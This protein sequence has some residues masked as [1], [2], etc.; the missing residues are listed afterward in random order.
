MKFKAH[1][2]YS[3]CS[4]LYLRFHIGLINV[5]MEA[6]R[7]KETYI[8][9]PRWKLKRELLTQIKVHSLWQFK[10]EAKPPNIVTLI[11]VTGSN[12]LFVSAIIKIQ[13]QTYRMSNL[14]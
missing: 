12:S 8:F 10:R 9:G 6:V 13:L 7:K 1:S 4:K 14:V 5:V 11:Q 3:S 2:K